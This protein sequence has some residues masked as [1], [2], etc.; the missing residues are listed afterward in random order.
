[1]RQLFLVSFSLVM[2]RAVLAVSLRLVECRNLMTQHASSQTHQLETKRRQTELMHADDQ[3]RAV[4]YQLST[5]TVSPP[6]H[7]LTHPACILTRSLLV[8]QCGFRMNWL[9]AHCFSTSVMES[10]LQQDQARSTATTCFVRA[11]ANYQ[12]LRVHPQGN[13]H[14]RQS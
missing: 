5:T 11:F 14:R 6:T 12:L 10:C 2:Q 4:H 9:V 3:L 1:M 8:V 7:A 13:N